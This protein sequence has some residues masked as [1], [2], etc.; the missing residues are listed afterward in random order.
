MEY[1]FKK[2]EEIKEEIRELQLQEE[3]IIDEIWEQ[4]QNQWEEK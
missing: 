1:L 2:W 4:C 3:Q